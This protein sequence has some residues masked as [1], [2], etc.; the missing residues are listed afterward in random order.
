MVK[1]RIIDYLPKILRPVREFNLSAEANQEEIDKLWSAINQAMDD[2][3]ILSAGESGISR[4]ENMLNI[5]PKATDSLKERA[6]RVLIRIAETLPYTIRTL[7]FL[8]GQLCGPNN[9][10]ID[11]YPSEHLISIKIFLTA[12]GNYQDVL[13]ML[14]RVLPANLI[15]EFGL[16]YNS[17]SDAKRITWK[18]ARAY[19]WR[20]IREEVI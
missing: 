15:L 7:H 20:S 6:F 17:W 16:K 4:W 12:K 11:R 10:S 8:L 1:R 5:Q 9:F 2:Q 19:T 13:D 18:D 3:F 14:D